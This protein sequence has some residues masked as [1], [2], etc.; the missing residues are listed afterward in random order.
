MT[1]T[2]SS[3]VSSSDSSFGFDNL[4]NMTRDQFISEMQTAG[5]TVTP[6]DNL[7]GATGA[8]HSGI[9][10]RDSNP[11]CSVHVTVDPGS[12]VYGE[13]VSGSFHVDLI[14]PFSFPSGDPYGLAP[15]LDH[16]AMDVAPDTLHDKFHINSVTP[17]N[18]Q[19]PN[20]TF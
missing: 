17:G 3:I 8:G 14:N 1:V 12:G 6:L 7:L 13:P 9:N 10:M 5:F 2:G 20:A 15:V 19:C 16:G 4:G 18:R 11:T